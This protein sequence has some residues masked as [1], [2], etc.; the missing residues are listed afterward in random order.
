MTG[1]P[2]IDLVDG[3]RLMDKLKDLRLG[4]NVQMIEKVGVDDA[5]FAT[6]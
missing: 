3:D 1:A 5:W 2:P 4:V 6:I